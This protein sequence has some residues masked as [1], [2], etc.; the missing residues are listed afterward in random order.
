MTN[1]LPKRSEVAKEQTWDA[2]S[3]FASVDA[4]RA[5][6]KALAADVES[7]GK[8]SG[9]LG[10]NAA[11]LA[12]GMAAAESINRQLSVMFTYVGMN[13]NVD[14]TDVGATTLYGEAMGVYGKVAA[15]LSFIEPEVLKIG[16]DTL[17]TWMTQEPRLAIYAHYFEKLYRRQEHVRSAEVEQVLGM[18]AE[19]FQ[20]ADMTYNMLTD[21]DLKFPS[22][23]DGKTSFDVAQSTIDT[24][25][26]HPDREVRK[27]AWTNY[28]G[29]YKA[30]KNTLSAS[31]M[32]AVKRD[33]FYGRARGYKSSLEAALFPNNI[34]T[35]VFHNLID[36]FKKNIPVWHRYFAIKKK[37]LGHGDLY[38][39]DIWAPLVK[40]PPHIPFD[41]GVEMIV[42][43]LK[44]LGDDYVNVLR[45][46]C[47]EERWVDYAPNQGK[48]QGAFSTGGPGIHPF[49]LMS[50]SDD[51]GSVSTLAHEL[52]HSMHTYLTIK[53]QPLVY[54]DYSLFVA[55]VASNF[56]QA[57]TR[58]YLLKTNDDPD[59]QI[60]AIT[61]AAY[62]FH[63]Y[64][65][66]MPTLARFEL[67]MHERAE[68]GQGVTA[69]DMVALMGDL[70][71][72]AYGEAMTIDKETFG[73]MWA[74]FG[75]LYANF[76][77]FQYATGISG[78]NALASRILDG[79]PG[80]AEAYLG[81]LKSGSSR[82]PLD[83]LKGAGVDLTT[84]EPVE[85][86]YAVLS[87]F[88]DRLEKLVDARD[89]K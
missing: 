35:A 68:R 10:D 65:L 60:T 40:N 30:Y 57:M 62:N 32:A 39:Y 45:K 75:H 86:T 81:F 50:Y 79:T 9:H 83:V 47:L 18:A 73:L 37:A 78:A 6:F 63:R 55:E 43:G 49:I 28:Y 13:Y 51:L 34:S 76:Y 66:Q 21:A 77:V 85:R 89:G 70:L 16:L 38:P 46:G 1:A 84:P 87:G 53:N 17:K 33:V 64:F 19:V 22:A 8:F 61:E 72:E 69:D 54:A 56:N 48:T 3:V 24:L 14:T 41:K 74:T 15:G 23:S 80:A 88:V 52:G 44:P 71:S 42:N 58:A 67:E 36:T 59:F 5:A 4:C 31:L 27:T 7:F 25:M 12:D 82:Y 11:M 29:Q 20:Q 2:E 26:D